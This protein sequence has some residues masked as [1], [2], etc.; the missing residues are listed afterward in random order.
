M[1]RPKRT[2]RTPRP[3]S[4]ATSYARDPAVRARMQRQ[5]TRDTAPELA[6]RRLLHAAGLRYRV[7]LAPVSGLRR[8]AD[9]VFA[10]IKV[11]VFVDGCFWHGCAAHGSRSSRTNPD[12]WKG[13]IARNQAR[14]LDTNEQL[15]AAG[16]TVIRVWE[17]EDPADVA[18]RI[19]L[20]V[21]ER[22][23]ASTGASASPNVH[24]DRL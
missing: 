22:R 3:S 4:E 11:A 17:H 10:R 14:D 8:R 23:Q 20:V 5:P 15:R 16:W 24:I 7:D 21:L 1:G 12:Y 19:G 9:L 18:R 6:V 2:M 13:K